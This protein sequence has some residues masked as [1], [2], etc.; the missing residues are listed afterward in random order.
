MKKALAVVLVIV[1]C[2]SYT[3]CGTAE[4]TPPPCG[5]E[6]Y[7][8]LIALLENGEYEGAKAWINDTYGL[9]ETEVSNASAN[10]S[11]PEETAV[12]EPKQTGI[13]EIEL[14][15][16]NFGEYFEIYHDCYFQENAFGDIS[17]GMMPWGIH[18]K[19]AFQPYLKQTEDIAVEFETGFSFVEYEI[20]YENRNINLIDGSEI[21]TDDRATYVCNLEYD[22]ATA[23]IKGQA[24]FLVPSATRQA[25]RYPTEV[26][27]LRAKGTLIFANTEYLPIT[28]NTMPP[29]KKQDSQFTETE[30]IELTIDNWDT[31]F[32]FAEVPIFSEN[33]FG[34]LDQLV[35]EY[36]FQLKDEYLARISE[37]GTSVV[38]EFNFTYGPRY[39]S[40]DYETQTYTLGEYRNSGRASEMGDLSFR[41]G[42]GFYFTGFGVFPAFEGDTIRTYSDFEVVRIQG[43]LCLNGE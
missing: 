40:V 16:E 24:A 5:H 25:F 7:L 9:V 1:L 11:A 12:A 33:A 31:Y 19:D 18:L 32:E 22:G 17:A 14:T 3:G 2:L 4:K 23:S 28:E 34:E 35:L 29:T 10:S 38:A 42:G 6:Q 37:D 27:V 20:D 26:A 15:P 43:T 36:R 13:V 39:C 30:K 8:S 21:P 41:S